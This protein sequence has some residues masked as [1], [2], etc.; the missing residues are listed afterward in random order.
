MPH[1]TVVEAC[2]LSEERNLSSN[3]GLVGLVSRQKR[4]VLR[5]PRRVR[6]ICDKPDTARAGLSR[7]ADT[8]KSTL[9]PCSR[10]RTALEFEIP[11]RGP[12]RLPSGARG[13]DAP[14]DRECTDILSEVTE[15]FGLLSMAI[16]D[17]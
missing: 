9:S 4:S 12:I 16:E 15:T 11:T 5:L 2:S 6:D 10:L 17:E 1:T 13:G 7:Q 3:T 8:R 14:K